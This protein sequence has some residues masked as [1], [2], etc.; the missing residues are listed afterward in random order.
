MRRIDES[1]DQTPYGRGDNDRSGGNPH[2][3][4]LTGGATATTG[5]TR[6]YL[7]FY[8]DGAKDR[9]LAAIGKDGGTALSTEAKL[10]YIV[11]RGPGSRFI[12]SLAASAAVAGVSSDREIGFAASDAVAAPARGARRTSR[13]SSCPRARSRWPGGSGT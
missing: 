4:T 13:G 9:A 12:E 1:R 2:R 11:A 7:V 6:D 10:G 3:G 5:Q 8:A